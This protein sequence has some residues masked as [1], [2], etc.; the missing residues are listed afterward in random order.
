MN[1]GV[2]NW[3][4]EFY[5]VQPEGQHHIC[6]EGRRYQF[7]FTRGKRTYSGLFMQLKIIPGQANQLVITFF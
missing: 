5:Q 4:H 6:V 1:F 7:R 2:I 3:K